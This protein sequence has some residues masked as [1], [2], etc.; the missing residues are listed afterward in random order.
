MKNRILSLVLILAIIFIA[1]ITTACKKDD[2][3]IIIDNVTKT[4]VT[5]TDTS[6]EYITIKGDTYSTWLTELDLSDMGLQDEDIIPLKYMINLI[7]LN[8][9]SNKINDLSPLIELPNLTNL[10]LNS[11]Q[12]S[13]LAPLAKLTNLTMLGLNHNNIHD[14]SLL[15]QL[16]NLKNL[17]LWGNNVS[18]LSP[19]SV[20]I[21][22]TSIDLSENEISDL[23]PLEALTNLNFLVL[24]GNDN[25]TQAQV[26]NLQRKLPDCEIIFTLYSDETE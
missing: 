26:N 17:Y 7:K 16:T 4:D 9:H 22:L 25:L 20:L 15:T 19:L 8:L 3:G 18:D 5:I 13:D 6:I 24:S 14:L 21:N 11:T 10:N 23:T 12:I 2:D 1:T